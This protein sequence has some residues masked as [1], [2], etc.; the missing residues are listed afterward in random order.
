[1]RAI[2]LY[3]FLVLTY[4]S[5]EILWLVLFMR[6]FYLEA[7][8]TL[9]RRDAYGVALIGWTFFLVAALIPLGIQVFVLPR[10]GDPVEPRRILLKAFLYGAILYASYDL[11]N[12]SLL[13]FW[14]WR[15]VPIDTLLGGT[16]CLLTAFVGLKVQ[17]YLARK[18]A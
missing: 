15:L 1:M 18:P 8:G 11:T 17:N 3:L 12:Y 6:D 9:T 10:I 16:V 7:L 5:I 4:L 2:K 14:P 13:R